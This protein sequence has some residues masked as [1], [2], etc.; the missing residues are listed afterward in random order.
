MTVSSI[1]DRK[2]K[3]RLRSHG[4]CHE[5]NS[6]RPGLPEKFSYPKKPVTLAVPVIFSKCYCTTEELL[7]DAIRQYVELTRIVPFDWERME[8]VPE[9]YRSHMRRGDIFYVVWFGF[10]TLDEAHAS[11]P[12]S[13][14]SSAPWRFRL[15]RR[16]GRI[17]GIVWSW[18]SK[19]LGSG[20]LTMPEMVWA[21]C[22]GVTTRT[23]RPR[24]PG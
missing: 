17:C 23:S 6:A 19:K 18:S 22:T 9:R 21:K 1:N 24:E 11:R 15:R 5:R 7:G 3:L 2:M 13:A 4:G 10:D 20:Q 14:R 8:P 16:S 12:S